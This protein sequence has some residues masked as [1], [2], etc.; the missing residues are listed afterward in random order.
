MLLHS[1]PVLHLLHPLLRRLAQPLHAP[2]PLRSLCT[3]SRSQLSTA[4][5]ALISCLSHSVHG[6]CKGADST[7]N[8]IR[9]CSTFKWCSSYCSIKW[10]SGAKQYQVVQ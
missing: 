5:S 6:S 3:T 9:Q 7:Q 4:D 2:H 8:S 10:H 1:L